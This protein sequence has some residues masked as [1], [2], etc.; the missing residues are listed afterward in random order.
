[1][2]NSLATICDITRCYNAFNKNG[3]SKLKKVL[4]ATVMLSAVMLTGCANAINTSRLGDM[5]RLIS[6]E[7]IKYKVF[8]I[9]G[10][11]FIGTQDDDGAWS[12]AGPISCEKTYSK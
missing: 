11:K 8:T 6:N 1:M 3:G 12:F 2:Y 4:F 7:G 10:A 9:E 5:P